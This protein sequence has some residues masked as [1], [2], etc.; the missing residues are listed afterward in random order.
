MRNY[1]ASQILIVLLIASTGCAVNRDRSS[2]FLDRPRILFIGSSSIFYWKTLDHDFA[3]VQGKLLRDGVGGRT[4]HDVAAH[5]QD[6]IIAVKPDKVLVYGGSIDLHLKEPRTPEQVF[7]DFVSL[8]DEVHASL[9][10]TKIYFISCKPSIAKWEEIESDVK[11]NQLVGRMA[12]T[13]PNAAYIDVF[14]PMLDA[15]GQPIE[16][17]FNKD[18][19]HL[20]KEGYA[21]WT[22]LIRPYLVEQN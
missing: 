3:D 22:K 8:C 10:S 16:A 6:E 21:L 14:N 20:N 5:V 15:N 19:N 2:T 7:G 17:L 1:F 9:P 11:L 18:H 12:A 4:L 13:E